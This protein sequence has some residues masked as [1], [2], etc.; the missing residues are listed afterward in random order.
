MFFW[1]KFSNRIFHS[2]VTPENNLSERLFTGFV[3]STK[4]VSLFSNLNGKFIVFSNETSAVTRSAQDL[5]K[6]PPH[7]NGRILFFELISYNRVLPNKL[8]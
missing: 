4:I 8:I 5:I 1:G 3:H 6:C 2:S 7:S